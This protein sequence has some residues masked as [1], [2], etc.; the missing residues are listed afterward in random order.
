MASIRCPKCSIEH[1]MYTPSQE[2]IH[3]DLFA[4]PDW[5]DEKFETQDDDIPFDC[6]TDDPEAE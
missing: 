6:Y 2:T 5:D 1:T 3:S 4:E